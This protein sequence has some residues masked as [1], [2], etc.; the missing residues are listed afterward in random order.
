VQTVRS[1]F[2][3]ESTTTSTTPAPSKPFSGLAAGDFRPICA[4]HSAPP[5]R[6]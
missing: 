3:S 5:I 6:V 4:S 2:P 1:A